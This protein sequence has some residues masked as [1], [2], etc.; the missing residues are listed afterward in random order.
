ML[1]RDLWLSMDVSIALMVVAAYTVAIVT[2]PGVRGVVLGDVPSVVN[3]LWAGLLGLV[4]FNGVAVL[5]LRVLVETWRGRPLAALAEF[6]AAGGERTARRD[7]GVT[8]WL[9]IGRIWCLTLVVALLPV[10]SGRPATA[11]AGLAAP[12]AFLYARRRGA[13][14]TRTSLLM[15]RWLA[16]AV[17]AVLL[18]AVALV[19]AGALGAAAATP[20]LR[21][22]PEAGEQAW[23]LAFVALLGT[24][25]AFA[26]RAGGAWWRGT[27]GPWRASL[28]PCEGC[29]AR[30]PGDAA[31]SAVL[32]DQVRQAFTYS[33]GVVLAYADA[34][35]PRA[36]AVS[37]VA[38]ISDAGE[39]RLIATDEAWLAADR[40]PRVAVFV[41]GPADR[42]FWAEVRGVALGDPDEDVLRVTPKQVIT[43][44][45][46]G[47]HQARA[48]QQG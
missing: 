45:Y 24:V 5:V 28:I 29:G 33:R 22:A 8:L 47:R 48:P 30:L 40:D 2:L 19:A 44:E 4:L 7:T 9:V 21:A 14:F 15:D 3:G 26:A 13:A 11:L 23:R 32:S 20:A 46:P 42:R 38:S 41:A 25:V 27:P 39:L 10:F 36:L 34:G 6:A 12:A 1:G 37:A 31:P 18:A 43:G 17:G 35:G 16:V